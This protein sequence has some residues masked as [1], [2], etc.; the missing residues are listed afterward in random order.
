MLAHDLPVGDDHAAEVLRPRPIDSGVDDDVSDLLG[1]EL[2]GL[3]GKGHEGINL[4]VGKEPD[5]PLDGIRY[6][7][8]VPPGIQAY[9][10]GHDGE[11]D[12]AARRQSSD[13]DLFIFEVADR[14]DPLVAEQLEAPDVESRQDD[15]RIA[16]VQAGQMPSDEPADKIGGPGGGQVDV[17]LSAGP[18]HV[19]DLREPFTTQQLLLGYV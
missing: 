8:D 15:D 9:V 16:R 18:L 10:P 2:L 12:V 5:R 11:E 17:V 4:S 7:L 6:P 13:G 14:P 19:L 1:A 3:G